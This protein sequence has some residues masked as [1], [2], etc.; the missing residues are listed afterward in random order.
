MEISLVEAVGVVSRPECDAAEPG[1]GLDDVLPCVSNQMLSKMTP[2]S[3]PCVNIGLQWAA[4]CE[5]LAR[6]QHIASILPQ[7]ALKLRRR[8]SIARGGV[9]ASR[10][11]D[12]SIVIKSVL[13]L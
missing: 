7:Y 2:L 13:R 10:L 6:K 8:T 12:R 9:L 4:L 11:S 1:C 3:T 5:S